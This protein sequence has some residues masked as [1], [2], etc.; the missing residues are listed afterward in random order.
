MLNVASAHGC[1]TISDTGRRQ[2]LSLKK[3]VDIAV[4]IM[5]TVT[6]AAACLNLIDGITEHRLFARA[7]EGSIRESDVKSCSQPIL[8]VF[9]RTEHA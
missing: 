8:E 1:Q 2:Y 9:C 7:V 3:R 4:S 6:Y 5:H